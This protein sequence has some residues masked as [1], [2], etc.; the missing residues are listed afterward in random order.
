VAHAIFLLDDG[1]ALL[2]VDGQVRLLRADGTEIDFALPGAGGFLRMNDRYVEV[3]TNSG[4]WALD[5]QAG[6][7]QVFLL[8]GGSR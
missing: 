7:E 1:S 2:A 4:M 5:T 3:I 8:P 6:S